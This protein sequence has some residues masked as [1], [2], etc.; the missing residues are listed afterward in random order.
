LPGAAIFIKNQNKG[1]VALVD[2]SFR[3]EDLCPGIWEIE[4]KYL[5]Y[6][7][8]RVQIKST[9]S[10]VQNFSLEQEEKILNEIIV[11]ENYQNTESMQNYSAL[12]GK[13]LEEAQGRTI[14]EALKEMT[15]VASIQTGPAISNLLF[16]EY[17]V[18]GY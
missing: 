15:G 2:G 6:K 9:S 1:T 12:T 18:N 4:V 10:A 3:I 14:G 17:I 16:M 7:T 13:Q 8:G 5:G 11:Q